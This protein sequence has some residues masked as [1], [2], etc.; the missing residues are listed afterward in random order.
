MIHRSNIVEGLAENCC[1][2]CRIG[3]FIRPEFSTDTN[4][5]S[6]FKC[7]LAM[8]PVTV[9]SPENFTCNKFKEKRNG[10]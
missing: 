5:M 8:P 4:I 1:L 7:F 2:N 9:E 3:K 10:H 6:K